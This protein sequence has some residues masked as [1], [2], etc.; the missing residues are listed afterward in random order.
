M[1]ENKPTMPLRA[2]IRGMEVGQELS[3]P[4]KRYKTIKIYCS[5]LKIC[6]KGNYATSLKKKEKI[7][8]VKRI[9]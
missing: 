6:E 8:T 9:S 1:E 7:I 2:I 3:F 4:I 5:D